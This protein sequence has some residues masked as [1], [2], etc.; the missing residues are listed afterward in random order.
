MGLKGFISEHKKALGVALILFGV[1][2]AADMLPSVDVPLS[3]RVFGTFL[4]GAALGGYFVGS[5]LGIGEEDPNW[6]YLHQINVDDPK[7]PKV[8]KVTDPVI[9]EIEII[10]GKRLHSP[11]GYPRHY[12]CRFFNEDPKNPVAHVTWKDV[13]D[14]WELLGT[15][16][17]A[18][19]DEVIAL[20]D[21]YEDTHGKYQWVL[22][23]LYMVVRKLD[24]Q[25]AQSQNAV[26]DDHLTPS[27]GDE[28]ISDVVDDVVPERLRPDRL[29]G[30]TK[31]DDVDD[32]SES[33][34][35]DQ[36]ELEDDVD[37][38][39]DA[40]AGTSPDVAAT[41]GGTADE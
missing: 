10:G 40:A 12:V 25:R 29:Q 4:I 18:I 8:S 20:R 17:S 34:D 2:W 15:Q 19:E 36:D 14:D 27:M 28:G 23:H 5:W 37:A 9:R 24:F 13:P 38:I 31:T 6:N 7:T 22:D 3:Y 33:I 39:A 41:D 1:L 21:T 30:A 35:Y 16:P 32:E 26:L 11:E